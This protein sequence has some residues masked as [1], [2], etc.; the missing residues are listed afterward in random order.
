M[1]L[2]LL[3]LLLA[4]TKGDIETADTNDTACVATAEICDT[5]DNDCDGL[6]DETAGFW[7]LDGDGDGWGVEPGSTSCNSYSDVPIAGDCDDADWDTFPGAAPN[8]SPSD[9]MTDADGDDWGDYAAVSPAVAGTD[10]NDSREHAYPGAAEAESSTDCMKDSDQDGWGDDTTVSPVV[11]GT[12]CADDASNTFPGSSPNDSTSDCMKDADGDDWGD[13]SSTFPVLAGS[14]CNDDRQHAYPGAAEAESATDCM[15]DSDQ[16]G[17][18]DSTTTSPVVS[19]TDCADNNPETHPGMA[20]DRCWGGDNDCDGS[21]DEDCPECDTS[22]MGVWS[23]ESFSDSSSFLGGFDD[24]GSCE[25]YWY[26][27]CGSGEGWYDASCG[28]M[29]GGLANPVDHFSL[30]IDAVLQSDTTVGVGV[31]QVHGDQLAGPAGSKPLNHPYLI[32]GDNSWDQN[33]P[34]LLYVYPPDSTG[35]RVVEAYLFDY[36]TT[37]GYPNAILKGHM[38]DSGT[39]LRFTSLL[40][41]L[42]SSGPDGLPCGWYTSKLNFS[43]DSANSNDGAWDHKRLRDNLESG[44]PFFSSHGPY[45][46]ECMDPPEFFSP[47][48]YQRGYGKLPTYGEVALV[49]TPEYVETLFDGLVA[50][51]ALPSEDRPTFLDAWA[52]TN[53]VDPM[54]GEQVLA[55][56]DSQAN[57]ATDLEAMLGVYSGLSKPLGEEEADTLLYTFLKTS[58]SYGMWL[59]PFGP[60][61]APP[62]P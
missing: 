59:D 22:S 54:M 51:E 27:D 40:G 56:W 41:R 53:N 34:A 47:T 9:C 11:S 44:T 26:Q 57:Y 21:L 28:E 14:D 2:L 42:Y 17:W 8:D 10:C 5:L 35:L 13:Y 1:L 38:D 31:W 50:A 32:S 19:G 33:G 43:L 52:T 3:L 18:G 62:I 4:C 7:Y 37:S 15:K 39:N 55:L 20:R 48:T 58:H 46:L 25:L 30:S 29:I 6:I 16:D 12:D 36:D 60:I 24:T 61:P 23:S 49:S 45:W